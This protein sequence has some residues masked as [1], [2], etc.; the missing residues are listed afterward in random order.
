MPDTRPPQPRS[1]RARDSAVG[2]YR[3][4]RS[5][6]DVGLALLTPLVGRE[7]LD[8]YPLRDPLN[9]GPQ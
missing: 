5:I 6:T 3:H 2:Q 9:R 1:A 7:F 8:K 4:K